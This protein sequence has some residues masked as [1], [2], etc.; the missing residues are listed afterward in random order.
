MDTTKYKKRDDASTRLGEKLLQGWTMLAV[1]CPREDCYTPL[2]RNKEGKMFCVGCDA[3]VITEEEAR[4]D[5]EAKEAKEQEEREQLIAAKFAQEQLQREQE[6]RERDL[7][8]QYERQQQKQQQQRIESTNG[9]VKRASDDASISQATGD[10]VVDAFR[11][12]ALAAMFKKLEE[13]TN[14]LSAADHS[15]RLLA[16]TKAIH[17]LASAIKTLSQ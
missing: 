8:L 17:E 13:L 7:Q 12:Q 1:H 15:E 9:P 5:Q 2:M 6:Q 10:D 4:R 16:T 14:S 3:F 11:R